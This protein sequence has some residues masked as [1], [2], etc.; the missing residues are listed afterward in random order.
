MVSNTPWA[1]NTALYSQLSVEVLA[2][3][4]DVAASGISL[5]ITI[6]RADFVVVDQKPVDA[7]TQPFVAGPLFEAGVAATDR[8]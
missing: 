7:G 1:F 2:D 6:P 5:F 8:P 4:G 3:L